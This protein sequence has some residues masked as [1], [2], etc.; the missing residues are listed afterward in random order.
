MKVF[1]NSGIVFTDEEGKFVVANVKVGDYSL[2]QEVY[3]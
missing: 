3:N 2:K 1:P